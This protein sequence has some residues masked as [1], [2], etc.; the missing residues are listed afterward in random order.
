MLPVGVGDR[1]VLITECLFVCS[2]EFYMYTYKIYKNAIKNY[3]VSTYG[4]VLDKILAETGDC[5]WRV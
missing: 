1:M 3:C 5:K 2:F 4:L